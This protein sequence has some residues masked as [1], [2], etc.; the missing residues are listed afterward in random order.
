MAR[1]LKGIHGAYSGKVGSIVGSHWRSVDYVRSVSRPTN[2]PASLKQLAQRERFALATAFL[3]PLKELLNL[4]YSDVQQSR[5]TGYN[6]ALRDVLKFA[7]TGVY[8]DFE[9]DYNNVRISRGALANLLVPQWSETAPQE[10]T[11]TW[12]KSNSDLMGYNDDSVILLTYNKDKKYFNLMET[13][14]R[15]DETLKINFPSVYAGDR[16]V[17]WVFTGH[18]DGV[19]TSTSLYIGELTLS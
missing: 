13:A 4:G 1:F 9:I 8:P 18:R 12:L 5:S 10:I 14:I 15:N 2:K 6:Q 19:K 16:V 17:G 3:G 11:M 7:I